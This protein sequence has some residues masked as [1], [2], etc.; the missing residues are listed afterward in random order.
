MTVI[1]MASLVSTAGCKFYIGGVLPATLADFTETSFSGQTWVEVDGW[2]TKGDLGESAEEINTALINRGRNVKQ[3][4]TFDAGTMENVFA[5]TPDDAGQIAMIAASKARYEYAFKVAYSDTPA[6]RSS[7]FTVTIAAPGV[8]TWTAHGLENGAAV[9]L[10][11]TGALPTGLAAATTY[12]VVNKATNTFQ[13]SA[14]K[15]GS[16]ITTTGTQSGVHTVTTQPTPTID[17]AVGLVLGA[18]IGGGGANDILT[19]SA[20]ISVSSNVLQ[21]A[22]LG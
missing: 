6:V 2:M 17:Y 14:T 15:G 19:I 13:L 16:S 7:V 18:P 1:N 12:Y 22:A 4:G 5:W 10:S 8:V 3:K 21:V 11:T 9:V 20:T